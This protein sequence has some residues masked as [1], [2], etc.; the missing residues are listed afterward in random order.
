[1]SKAEFLFPEIGRGID[2][3]A[4]TRM[5]VT[6][7]HPVTTGESMR[8]RFPKKAVDPVFADELT[9]TQFNIGDEFTMGFPDYIKIRAGKEGTVLARSVI[10][11]SGKG[12]DPVL[13]VGQIGKGK[14]ILCG[15]AIGATTITKEKKLDIIEKVTPGELKILINSVYWLA[16]LE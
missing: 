15:T 5:K 10:D 16:E 11:E 1:M 14:V 9:R 7:L 12:D 13:V 3:I 2:W 8:K 4:I 6:K